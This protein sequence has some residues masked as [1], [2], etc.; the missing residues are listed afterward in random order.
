MKYLYKYPQRAYPYADLVEENRRR[1]R[2]DPEYE[3]LDT[4]IFEDDRYF[5]VCV[6]Y[7]KAAPGDMLIR[8][9]RVQ[10]RPLP[11]AAAPAAHALVQ[12]RL[13]VDRRRNAKPRIAVARSG[14]RGS[15]CRAAHRTLAAVLALL[16]AAGRRAVH[17]ERNQP[18]AH[19]RRAQRVAVRQGRVQRL[20]RRRHASDAVNPE[21][22]RHQGRG[23]LR[24]YPVGGRRNDRGEAAPERGRRRAARRSARRSTRC[25][26]NAQ[27]KPTCSTSGSRRSHCPTT[28]ATCSGRR[29]P[30][31]CGTSNTTATSW[32]AGSKATR[33]EPPPP[34]VAQER[35]QPQ[36]VAHVAAD[37]VLSMP[38]KWEYPWF[39]AW[40]M[41]FHAIPFAMIDPDFAKEQLLLLTREWYMHPN[42]QIPAYEW[43]F[44]DVNPPVHAWAAMRVYQ[45]EEKFYGRTRPRFPRA[46]LP[47]AAD[48]LH[49]VGEPQGR[50]RQQHL[51]RRL[52][53][54]RQHQ[55]VRPHVRPALGR[56]PR[57]GRRHELDGDVLPQPAGHRARARQEGRRLRGRRDQ[58]LRAL[59]LHRRGDQ[60]DGRRQG[61][62]NED[63]GYYYDVLRLPDG[64]CI[65]IKAQT[66]LRPD[67]DLRRRGRAIARR[68][69]ALRR[70]Q[71][72]A[73]A[74]SRSTGRTCCAGWAT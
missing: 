26:R 29:S 32:N 22:E 6:E 31:C 71:R 49:V 54:P 67:P 21:R 53:R 60:Q 61:L 72:S 52:P 18:A 14:D 41:A 45:I 69:A 39:A 28:C 57:A 46:H 34:A 36:L 55:R 27:A 1:T 3:L 51:R 5:D 25:S 23:A 10:P 38:D 43:A 70:F 64:R 68:S 63:D 9:Q 4:G 40:D 13:D 7:A 50:R 58:V 2:A 47:E 20:R 35:A 62:W 73:C 44:C 59:R 11:R 48:Q 19:F 8:D 66:D 42:G 30:A 33:P 74:G 37:D 24:P 65:P 16:R 15:C 17:R 12:E 56:P